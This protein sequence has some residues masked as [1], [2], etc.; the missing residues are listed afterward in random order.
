MILD[1]QS[2]AYL[3]YISTI[4]GL[5]TTAG[6][7]IVLLLGN[8][9]ERLL[10]VLLAGAGGV[11]LAVVFLDLLP[12]A[13]SYGQPRQLFAGLAMGAVFMWIADKILHLRY[14][15]MSKSRSSFQRLKRTGI[16]VASGIALHDIPEGM[17]IAVGQESTSELGMLIAIGIALHNLP[18]GMAK[19]GR[20]HV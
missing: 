8:P 12:L 10:A 19:I 5:A 9:P 6:C 18:E 2:Y 1:N 13:L 16:L 11:M 7:M 4:A 15:N 20:A 17:A 3:L 14:K